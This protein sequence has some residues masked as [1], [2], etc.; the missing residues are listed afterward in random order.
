[1]TQQKT[2]GKQTAIVVAPGRG[3]YNRDELGYF[4][5]HH[6]DKSDLMAGFD[7]YRVSQGQEPLSALDGAERFSGPRHTRGDNA[8]GLIHACALADFMSIDRERFDILGVTGNSMGWYIALACA[9]VL[10]TIG[11]LEVVNTMGT[12]MHEHMIGGQ[13][14]YPFMDEN[15]VEMPGERARIEAKLAEI[16][17]RAD[18]VLTLSI[19]LGGMLVLAGNEA[20]LSAFER[21]MPVVQSRFPL[22]LPGHA[23][24]HTALQA[25]VAAEGRARLGAELFSNPDLPLI[26]GRGAIWHPKASDL[27]ELR[28]Y[29]LGHQVVEPYDF[30]GAIGVAAR[31]FMP[32]VFIVLGPGT[33]LGGGVVQSLI[34]ANW[35][36]MDNKETFKTRQR[37]KPVIL[38][39]GQAD[40]RAMVTG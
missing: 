26:D 10:D 33:T 2:A 31:E 3:T 29:T 22:R 8:S 39:M 4:A 19:D 40:Q 36:A 13:L 25:P 32:D 12:L 16:N 5:H 38:S 7:A 37:S 6:E 30:T 14:I 18:H 9:G 11:G 15:W 28:S 34:R 35:R 17:A 23:G 21:E 1:M 24:F 20:G 27:T